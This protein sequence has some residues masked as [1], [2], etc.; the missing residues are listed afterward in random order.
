LPKLGS[1]R[2]EIYRTGWP[3]GLVVPTKRVEIEEDFIRL[4]FYVPLPAHKPPKVL[5][6]A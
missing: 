6:S 2:V 1:E 5:A 3:A 4:S